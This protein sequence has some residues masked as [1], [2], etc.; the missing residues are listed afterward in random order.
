MNCRICKASIVPFMSFGKMPIANGFLCKDDFKNE[1]FYEMKV[2]FCSSCYMFQLVDQPEPERMFHDKY[3][4]H[5]KT[6]RFMCNHFSNFADW[7]SET[8]L[9]KTSFV[10]E[11]GSND[12]IMLEKFSEHGIKHLGVDP[13][14]NVAEIARKNGL[15]TM[16]DFFNLK[17]AKKIVEEYGKADV[18]TGGNVMCHIGEIND[19]IEGIN[20]L[21]KHDGVAVFEDPYLG[22]MIRKTAYDQI[23][24]EH[25]FMFSLHSVSNMFERFGFELIDALPQSTHGGSMRYVLARKGVRP[26][27]CRV[28]D[29]KK[30]EIQERLLLS[31]T[32]EQF[33]NRCESSKTRLVN[34]LKEQKKKEKKV[35]GYGATSKSTTILNY[36]GIG[37]DLIEYISDITPTKIG[38]YTPGTHVPVKSYDSFLNKYPDVAVLFAWNHEKEILEKE[39]EFVKKGGEWYTH[40]F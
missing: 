30:K 1:Y 10:V 34:F 24:D 35:V 5:A 23:Y 37:P 32:Y 7:L 14:S 22:E 25:V 8:Y 39:K 4:Y 18:F 12:G 36:C 3:A 9:E 17:T 28:H 27:S 6:S 20:F 15:N 40:L 33:R 16:V 11:V 2:A 21:L 31:E 38:K 26:V 29:L 19:V 13:S